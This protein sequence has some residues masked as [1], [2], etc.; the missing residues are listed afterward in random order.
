[1]IAV[2]YVVSIILAVCF[3]GPANVLPIG[4]PDLNRALIIGAISGIF[5]ISS[6]GITQ[7][8]IHINGVVLPAVFGKI[9]GLIIPLILSILLFGEDPSIFQ[10]IGAV[11]A[12]SA[13]LLINYHKDGGSARKSTSMLVIM[14]FVEGFAA[15]M[16]KIYRE[17]GNSALGDHF[18]LYT[19][20]SALILNIII[21]VIKRQIPCLQDVIFGIFVGAS[22][23]FSVR[24]ALVALNSMPAVIVYPSRSVSTL[25]LIAFAGI[26]FFKEKLSRRHITALPIIFAALLLLNL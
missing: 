19:F 22:N 13:I 16:S 18:L 23:F 26:F 14:L 2:N 24:F 21:L 11:L 1:M 12:I 4:E 6:M 10:C 3:I 20:I 25:A 9:G 15:A 7:Y 8:N 17:L 5:Y